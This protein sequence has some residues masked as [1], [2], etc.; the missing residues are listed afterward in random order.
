MCKVW[1]EASASAESR[2]S[3]WL[4]HSWVISNFSKLPDEVQNLTPST[5]NGCYDWELVLF[6]RL[7]RP[8][9]ADEG[10]VSAV[11][12]TYLQAR[13]SAPHFCTAVSRR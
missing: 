3:G 8:S 9:Y 2:I 1:R 4:T 10:E 6:P 12:G 13:F 7:H 11:L 5:T